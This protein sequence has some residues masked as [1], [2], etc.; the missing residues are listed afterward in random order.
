M[1]LRAERAA[2]A[3][4]LLAVLACGGEETVS[5]GAPA[6]S[7]ALPTPAVP[8]VDYATG[9]RVEAGPGYRVVY[10]SAA[11]EALEAGAEREWTTAPDRMV[12]VAR[13][14]RPSL[15][16]ELETLPRF[17]VPVERVTV[18]RDADAL[19]VKALDALDRLR[20]IGGTGIYDADISE[21]VRSGRLGAVGSA[22]HR[23]TNT[24]FL[25]LEEIEAAFFRVASLAHA[26]QFE[27]LR[28][29]GVPAV[30][31]FTWAERSYLGRAEWLKYI[32]LFLGVEEEADSLFR[33]IEARRD[34]L[35]SIVAD[36]P[37]VPAVWAY[38]S[39]DRWIVHRNSL[40]SELLRDAGGANV[41]EDAG[42]GVSEGRRG[43]TEGV[44]M[45]DEEF[46]IAAQEAR[47][48]ITWDRTDAEW[49]SRAYLEQIPAYRDDRVFHHRL[50]L[51]PEQGA[52]IG[53]RAPRSTR[54]GC[55]PI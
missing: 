15:P 16:S 31:V 26:Q 11:P 30:P 18:N 33:D 41:L 21:R 6:T 37:P 35:L 29:T 7:E 12:L 13:G 8:S 39:G 42:A 52:T 53:T 23:T 4:F 36:Q 49:P 28:E 25:L 55:S 54:P 9:F 27:R 19:R 20:G 14:T 2:L 38:R 22:L 40:E 3:G 24:E 45:T 17:E 1:S 46:L 50:R 32:A 43:F 44:P 47:Y 34:A 48:W 10:A 51:R 5:R